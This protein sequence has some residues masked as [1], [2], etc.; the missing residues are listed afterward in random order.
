M[1]SNGITPVTAR[2]DLQ[3]LE[4][5]ALE[6]DRVEAEVGR[7]PGTGEPDERRDR[8]DGQRQQHGADELVI[9]GPGSAKALVNR[10]IQL[11]QQ[12]RG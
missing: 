3:A 6:V 1:N 8:G 12:P 11:F 2:A 10:V 9:K 7:A 5:L 4:R